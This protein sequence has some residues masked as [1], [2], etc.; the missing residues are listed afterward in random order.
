MDWTPER[1]TTP[2]QARE[3]LTAH[4]P[5]LGPVRLEPV[6]VGWDNVVYRVNQEWLFRFPQRQI[7]V[8]GVEREIACLPYLADRLP[9]VPRPAFT[10]L[11]RGWPFF[12]YRP[13][14]G[15]EACELPELD[16]S[17]LLEPLADFLRRLHS[18]ETALELP[19]DPLGRLSW[20]R[21]LPR[22]RTMLE[23]LEPGS[24]RFEEVLR[25][26]T[27]PTETPAVVHGD[28]HFRH[29]MLDETGLRGVIDW[30]DLHRNDPAIDLH[31]AWTFFPPELREEFWQAY[32]PVS[33]PQKKRARAFGLF[34]NLCLL[35]YGRQEQIPA[36]ER[37]ALRA[38]DYL[39][40]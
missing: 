12:G 23:R 17:L 39:A 34:V 26:L 21:R 6:G 2:E 36:V 30:G 19:V 4:F 31:L 38:L 7:A 16:R 1:E 25:D 5:E 37:E 3:L 29:L 27:N 24:S 13:I 40:R 20:E 8:E 11:D 14:P 28:L 33:E 35:D 9:G 18:P 15:R 22:I 32:G 10:G